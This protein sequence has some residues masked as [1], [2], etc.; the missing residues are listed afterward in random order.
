MGKD[1]GPLFVISVP[2]EGVVHPMVS[3]LDEVLCC[4]PSL[5]VRMMFPLRDRVTAV[6]AILS[7]APALRSCWL[8]ASRYWIGR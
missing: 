1:L 4:D 5:A 6:T 7:S 8:N 3:V 2:T